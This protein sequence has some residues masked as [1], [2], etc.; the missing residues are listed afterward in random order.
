MLSESR[1]SDLHPSGGQTVN[2]SLFYV[3][4]ALILS[5]VY[6]FDEVLNASL[7]SNLG[8]TLVLLVWAA[9]L[10]ARDMRSLRFRPT[11][12]ALYSVV[13][14]ASLISFATPSGCGI[15]VKGG[16]SLF[17]LGLLAICFSR[18]DLARIVEDYRI[19]RL[20]LIQIL[21]LLVIDALGL[22]IRSLFFG[23]SKGSG[24][25]SET[26]HLAVYLL[27]I[28]A[29]RLL[30]APKD[31]LAWSTLLSAMVLAP[32]STLLV[33]ILATLGI[34]L[35]SGGKGNRRR[36]V[37]ILSFTPLFMLA[38]LSGA[39]DF[40]NT[41]N[42]ITHIFSELNAEVATH[43]NLSAIVWLNGWSQAA[44]TLSSSTFLGAGFNQMGCGPFSMVGIFSPLLVDNLGVVLNANDGSLLA[45]K[46]IAE[47]GVVGLGIV[48]I[49]ST[50]SVSAILASRKAMVTY[51]SADRLV[52]T[53]RAVGGLT[54]L[55][56]LFVRG[57]GYFQIP[58]LLG[59]A[60]LLVSRSGRHT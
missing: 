55:M 1:I 15:E 59:I 7:G 40:T 29:V 26:S 10:S 52:A 46:L 12:L 5:V 28:I 19:T 25:Y 16:L 56:Y 51:D 24:P 9:I 48:L 58:I 34:F 44:E 2:A 20:I 21:V 38:I 14:I 23:M 39:V 47:L 36:L 31:K 37:T 11:F 4:S 17:L 27:P 6:V 50:K 43:E 45:A 8:G 42:R 18:F 57:M 53:V 22:G 49:L 13:V 54:I 60:M 35:I 32:S 33:G 30:L 41:A 3:S